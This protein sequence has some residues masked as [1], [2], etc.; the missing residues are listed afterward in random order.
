VTKASHGNRDMRAG[1]L[2]KVLGLN[3]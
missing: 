1:M 3:E 2:D